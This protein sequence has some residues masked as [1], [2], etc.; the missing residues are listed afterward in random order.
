M[1]D[2]TADLTKQLKELRPPDEKNDRPQLKLRDLLANGLPE[3]KT[4]EKKHEYRI[5]RLERYF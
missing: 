3:P 5:L 1:S 4:Q 2:M